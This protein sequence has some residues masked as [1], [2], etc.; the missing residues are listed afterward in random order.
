MRRRRQQREQEEGPENDHQGKAAGGAQEC[1]QPDAEADKADEGTASEG[2]RAAHEG[3]PSVVPEQEEQG[4]A[5]A[6]DALHGPGA[7]PPSQRQAVP[8]WRPE[9]LFPSQRHAIPG[10]RLPSRL[11]PLRT[12]GTRRSSAALHAAPAAARRIPAPSPRSGPVRRPAPG[13]GR[14]RVQPFSAPPEA[15]RGRILPAPLLP[16][17]AA[18]KSRFPDAPSSFVERRRKRGSGQRR[19]HSDFF[20]LLLVHHLLGCGR[21]GDD[22][23]TQRAVLPFAASLF[24]VQHPSGQ[25]RHQS[26][27]K[28]LRNGGGRRRTI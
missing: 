23:A 10:L 5:D 2:D 25:H 6:P 12:W 27:S 13:H 4:E 8:R 1:L 20:V 3:D 19:L 18:S 24:G 15:D 28:F 21:G 14:T 7:I 11:R 9:V 17:A 26:R 22:A 16:L